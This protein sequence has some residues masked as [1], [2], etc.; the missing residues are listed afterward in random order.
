MVDAPDP[1]VQPSR[2]G[3]LGQTR[4]RLVI[5]FS[6]LIAL[7]VGFLFVG[8]YRFALKALKDDFNKEAAIYSDTF[9]ALQK[10]A[11]SDLV[12]VSSIIA[13]DHEV[14][15]LFLYGRE[16]V[17]AE[18]GGAGGK[19]AAELR[20]LLF[21]LVNPR[22]NFASQKLEASQLHFH[23]A[24]GATSFLRIHRPDK[25]GD[26][27]SE[28]RPSVV[29]TNEEKASRSGFEI[30]RMYAGVRGVV[31]VFAQLTSNQ[32]PVHVGA[33]ETGLSYQT[34]VDTVKDITGSDVTVL[35][36]RPLA[37]A[38][39][40]PDS[41]ERRLDQN[42]S[43]DY[44][45]EA[46]S[47]VLPSSIVEFLNPSPTGSPTKSAQ[48]RFI[49]AGESHYVATFFPLRDYLGNKEPQRRSVGQVV[50]WQ[51]VSDR[52]DEFRHNQ[53]QTL[54][55]GIFAYLLVEL[56]MIY[57]IGRIT[58][59]LRSE[60]R[61]S[62][63]ALT[64]SY[65][66]RQFFKQI[67]DNVE[68]GVY[69]INESGAFE[70]V[71]KAV[72]DQTGYDAD[73][74]LGMSVPDV[75]VDFD[76]DQ[77]P[78]HWRQLKQFGNVL[79]ESVHQDHEGNTYPVEINANLIT[80]N[81][82]DYNLAL[83]RDIS[84]RK[85]H[86]QELQ[87]SGE[88][89]RSIIATARDGF[90]MVDAQGRVIEV[91][92][93]Y[94]RMTGFTRGELL[95]RPIA[96]LEANED[97]SDV[98][99]HIEH[100]I[101]HGDDIFE[102]AHWRKDGTTLP[103]EVAVSYTAREGGRFFSFIRD[104]HERKL[105]ERLSKLRDSLSLLAHQGNVEIV[106]RAAL[107]EAEELTYSDIAFF[108]FVDQGEQ[109]ISLQTWS[110]RT[111]HEMCTATGEELHY[112]VSEAGVWVDCIHQRRAVIHND[113]AS[114]THRKGL[115]E[116]H[117]PLTR[118]ATV[119]VFRDDAIV[120][121]IGVGNKQSFYE[122][123]DVDILSRVADMTYDFA[124]HSETKQHV[125]Y[126]AYYDV[127]TGLPNR[128][129]LFERLKQNIA[130]HARSGKMLALCYLDL[131]G[132]KPINDEHGHNV[133]DQLLIRLGQRLQ[134]ALREGDTIARI[135]GDEFVI[136]LN[137]LETSGEAEIIVKRLIS[138]TSTPFDVAGNRLYVSASVGITLY[139]TDDT[140]PDTLLRHADQAM[141][142]A[143]GLGKSRYKM[144]ELIE[145]ETQRSRREVQQEV[146]DGLKNNEFVL[147]F[148]P[149]ID[150]KSGNV[151]GAEALIRWRH[152]EKGLLPP[153][154]FLG[155]VEGTADEIALGE[156]VVRQ[157]LAQLSAWRDR[158]IELPVSIN[159]SPDHIQKPGFAQFLREA[160]AE[161]PPQLAEQ[162]E[163]E[164]LETAAIGDLKKVAE[165]M[166]ECT[167]SGVSFSLDD[168]GTG[169]SSLTYF[170][171][172]PI[173][174]LKI[175][176]NFVRQ[177]LEQ[178]GDLEI[179]KG[180]I[181]LAKT[182][183]R[184]VVAEGVENIELGLML[185]DLGCEFAQGYGIAKPMPSSRMERWLET[186]RDNRE[187]RGLEAT[188]SSMEQELE[189]KVALFS[190]R[191]WQACVMKYL[192]VS[193]ASEK[194]QLDEKLSEFERWYQGVGRARYGTHALYTF[195]PPRHRLVHKLARDLVMYVDNGD[196]NAALA[197]I[198]VFN[199]ACADLIDKLLGLE[200]L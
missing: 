86:E 46:T 76:F 123:K 147:Y 149:R 28:V 73:R 99:A 62:A 103:V 188:A 7:A 153:G 186:W 156:W 114:L 161:Y 42:L 152:P 106:L 77:W 192:T 68:E 112:P 111:L 89:Y 117:A 1:G 150:L 140:N 4:T 78:E 14:Q 102:S 10:S 193:G 8:N 15:R 137:A 3:I 58:R 60:V 127:L 141:Y 49:T 33:L 98:A 69:L 97:E 61:S 56:L 41:T 178:V 85:Q 139:P 48:A 13:S 104:I 108:H 158:G 175:D 159:I 113:Y 151:V 176:Q 199:N 169:Y 138:E 180:V 122:E 27:L 93:S 190:H 64:R 74:L 124:R 171:Q 120:A 5:A 25:F 131:D 115:P 121:I 125:E 67:L 195:I 166:Q 133:G 19:R 179:V 24:P 162:V 70:F 2:P 72:I 50:I 81:E 20:Q 110:S 148:Q 21:D 200:I 55:L 37:E 92:E 181:S 191:R 119:P 129:L 100:I 194:P 32:P 23:L 142:I 88:R 26:D 189:L 146:H 11:E 57:G 134:S 6:V 143:K 154:A 164:I 75:D 118:F 22:W 90:V 16:A 105:Q 95:Q 52:M 144:Y 39:M 59:S 82:R 34:I 182:L 12:L 47:S 45:V 94:C 53:Q 145:E 163:L 183:N 18:G 38:V 136:L 198:E 197:L 170:H 165:V 91:N 184:P 126:M 132:F 196:T 167:E 160:L 96:D 172:L 107:D 174:V 80:Y 157:A 66:Q 177:M 31:P 71:N 101:K 83:V 155:H 79:F 43:A 29:D 9:Y 84:V 51:D 87:D 187:W 17:E 30:G 185:L 130:Q 135:G 173:S 36:N 109:T 128:E 35:L 63:R 116:G 54:L 65:T 44:I 168:F 40:W